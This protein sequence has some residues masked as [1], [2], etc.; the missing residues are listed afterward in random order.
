MDIYITEELK[1][2]ILSVARIEEV[3]A[4]FYQLKKSGI[5]LYDTCPK[6]NKSGKSK[7]MII[8][9]SKQ[10]YKCFSCDW[11]GNSPVNFLMETQG[12]NYPEA[13]KHLADKYH[14][15]Y[16]QNA[17]PARGSQKKK[18]KKKKTFLEQQLKESGLELMDLK[19][20]IKVD[21]KTEKVVD[22]FQVGTRN[23]YGQLDFTGNDII[24]FYYDL[25]GKPVQYQKPNSKKMEHLFRIRW[26][27][28][29]LHKDK[30]GNPMKYSSPYGSVS[31]LYIPEAIRKIYQERRVLKRLFIQEGEKKAEKACK[32]GIPSVGIMGIQN[33]GSGG[34]LPYEFQLL[35][36]TCK[37]EE[38]IFVLDQDWDHLSAN[39][40]LEKPVDQRPKNFFY[41]IRNFKEYFRT[42]SNMGIYL[43]IYFA[44]IRKN[45]K[46]EK[47][48]DDLL[49][50]SLAG[51][52][53]KLFYDINEAIN[54][55]D[56]T[57]EFIQVNK[58]TTITDGKLQEFWGLQSAEAFF[59]KYK[60]VLITLPEFRIGKHL[61]KYD[62]ESDSL[63]L[64]QPL[65][66]NEIFWETITWIDS[67]GQEKT[68]Y[69]FDYENCY[70]FLKNRGFGRLMMASGFFE[71]C[72]VKDSVVQMLDPYQIKDYIMNLAKE[73]APKDI[74]NML[75]RGGKMYFGQ[76]S[77]SNI[78]FVH[79]H[80]EIAAKNHQ[81]LF[82]KDK[83]WKITADGI[84]EQ[85][86]SDLH[87]NVWADK[88]NNFQATLVKKDLVEVDPITQDHVGMDF[89][90]EQITQDHV[91]MFSVEISD[92][93]VKSHF[94][95]FLWNTSEFQ[96]QKIYDIKD[97]F[98][99]GHHK[100][101][102]VPKSDE[103]N[104]EEKMETQMHFISKLTALGKLLH[105]FFDKSSAK[106]VIGMDGKISEVG[107]SNGGTGK[108]IF[109][110][111]IGKVIPQVSIGAKNKKLTEDPFIFEE[112]TE[113]TS[114]VF[115]DDV[116]A[117]VDFEFFFPYITG[118]F[119][120]NG[121][122][123]KKFTIPEESTPSMYISTNHAIVGEGSS[124][125]RRQHLIAFSDFYN[126]KHIPIDDFGGNFFDE[127]DAFQ[128]NLFYN[129]MGISL[130]LYFKYGLIEA[131]TERLEQRRLRQQIGED[132]LAWADEFFGFD[133]VQNC[134]EQGNANMN[135]PIPRREMY[136]DFVGKYPKQKAYTTATKFKK[137]VRWYANYRNAMYNPHKFFDLEETRPGADDKT[138]GVEYFTLADENYKGAI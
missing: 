21:D 44:N 74:R 112:V 87:S 114:N 76:D 72:Q 5:S 33:I 109:G 128:W 23:Q 12:M 120:V 125:K 116:R 84:K 66:D 127:W 79:P 60:D 81:L 56:G 13:M 131:P 93:G 97:Q 86:L 14:L 11:G 113:K 54:L 57:G 17:K 59:N 25:E 31:H 77:L 106:A 137:K 134:F 110:D 69:Q 1:E 126:D 43:E 124:F 42:F 30:N 15:E 133:E 51:N 3:A 104:L 35:I 29:D 118:K 58:I 52:E 7:G 34:K 85:K 75:Y 49:A 18:G 122:G 115:L 26:Q 117:N 119:L 36:Q 88:I 46:Q 91:G 130:K 94:L 22:P 4:D 98:E 105:R 47:G 138:G 111:A 48:I 8:T 65:A 41:A 71:F 83:F 6:C 10:I 64:A 27:N 108:S 70:N 2:K 53:N 92:E 61:W 135:H 38:V 121:K 63:Q 129:L 50:G 96:W 37:V 39:L 123:T 82:F 32:H 73:I 67:R 20:T 101:I 78:D 45:E 19:A 136:D 24:I 95:K 40:S 100:W 132:F 16:D 103:R 102:Y 107:A 62:E 9:P 28:P 55:K 90:G 99:H 68:K 89:D 80:F